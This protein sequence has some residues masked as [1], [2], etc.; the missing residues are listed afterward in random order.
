MSPTSCQLL[1]P[2]MYLLRYFNITE[3]YVPTNCSAAADSTPQYIF[4]CYF[5]LKFSVENY[6]TK[7]CQITR[8]CKS[9][10]KSLDYLTV[11]PASNAFSGAKKLRVP[12]SS[13]AIKTIP[14]DSIP[15]IFLGSKLSN[16]RTVFPMISSGV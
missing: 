3:G 8:S 6:K 13:S 11:G 4:T 14:C 16:T 1:H 15:R 5:N 12:S 10:N 9:F 7:I 2:A